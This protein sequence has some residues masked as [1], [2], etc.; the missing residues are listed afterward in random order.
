MAFQL[1]HNHKNAVGAMPHDLRN[2]VRKGNALLTSFAQTLALESST[3]IK[4][5]YYSETAILLRSPNHKERP[6]TDVPVQNPSPES[7]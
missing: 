6:L 5:S 2:Q 1:S 7:S 3:V 4:N